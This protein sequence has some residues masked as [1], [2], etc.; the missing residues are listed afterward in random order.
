MKRRF[1]ALALLAV[2]HCT[3]PASE[4]DD[5]T[6]G[7]HVHAREV[8]PNMPQVPEV[9]GERDKGL[10][11]HLFVVRKGPHALEWLADGTAVAHG[12]LVQVGYVA[13]GH[14]RGVIVSI[15]GRGQVTLHH[16]AAPDLPPRLQP[17]GRQPLSFAFELDDAQ[18]FE[19][20]VFVAA[21]D[22]A[23]TPARVLE[24]AHQVADGR[25]DA[26]TARLPLPST[27][28]QSSVLLRKR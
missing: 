23:L 2:T 11:P 27:W 1:T 4:S 17:R 22:D 14:T 10:F 6:L 25:S 18:A 16:P 28:H 20:F 8:T 7:A 9:A 21:A 15:D 26:A 12:D 19:R 13:A 24:A 5:A 3:E